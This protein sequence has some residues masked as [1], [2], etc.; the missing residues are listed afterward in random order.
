MERPFKH[1]ITRH[2]NALQHLQNLPQTA[3]LQSYL[4]YTQA[5]A[6]SLSHAW[7]LA[8]LL[9]KPVQRL[10]KYPLLLNAIFE[11]TP[12]AHGDKENLKAARVCMEEVAQRVNEGRRRAEVVKDVLNAKGVKKPNASVGVAASVNLSKMKSL[13]HGGVAAAT[14]R[15][16]EIC[17]RSAEARAFS[18]LG[19]SLPRVRASHWASPKTDVSGWRT[20]CMVVARNSSRT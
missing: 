12:D 10:L 1:Y 16:A 14:I 7:D 6:S 15:L 9:I 5:V 13:R 8:S 19:A 11:T 4:K 3:A 20:S 18:R 2:P 17:M